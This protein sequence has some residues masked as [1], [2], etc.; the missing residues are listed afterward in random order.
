MKFGLKT[1]KATVSDSIEFFKNCNDFSMTYSPNMIE[2]NVE[3]PDFD[4]VELSEKY[5][6]NYNASIETANASAT[7]DFEEKNE[8][9]N[10]V[11]FD[12]PAYLESQTNLAVGVRNCLAVGL[13]LC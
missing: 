3:E 9:G 8:Q 13:L 6:A 10:V 5:N 2:W 4:W 7:S 12:Y 1:P 11:G